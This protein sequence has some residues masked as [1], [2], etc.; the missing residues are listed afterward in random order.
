MHVNKN[1]NTELAGD[2]GI[3]GKIRIE[4]NF[5]IDKNGDIINITAEGGPEVMND[6]AVEVIASIPTLKPG[7]KNG[8]KVNVSY[9]LPILFQVFD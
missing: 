9:V 6:N 3:S 5:I 8:E 7:M 4:V 1:F 2:L